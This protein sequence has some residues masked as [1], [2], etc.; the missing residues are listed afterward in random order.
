VELET[1]VGFMGLEHVGT[2]IRLVGRLVSAFLENGFCRDINNQDLMI[3][4]RV[5]AGLNGEVGDRNDS[6]IASSI[7]FAILQGEFQKQSG[8]AFHCD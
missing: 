5:D 7:C 4:G 3:R 2:L 6:P 1:G 8:R